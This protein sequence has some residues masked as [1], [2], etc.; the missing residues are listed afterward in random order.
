MEAV[1]SQPGL[2][3]AA[4]QYGTAIGHPPLRQA[5]LDRML[6]A[7]GRSA[8]EL[9][10]SID[11]VVITAGSHQ[12]L[13]LVSD[14]LCDPG[15][16]VICAAPSYYVYLGTLANLGVRAAGVETDRFGMIPEAVADELA[17][18]KTAGELGRVKAIYI[19]SYYDN[20]SGA[21]VPLEAPGGAGG[22]GQTLVARAQDLPDRRRRLP[23]AALCRGGRAQPAG[24]RSG[25]RRR[26]PRRNLFQV[27]F[28]GHSGGLG[29]PAAGAA[30]SGA[31]R[32]GER[33][34]RLAALQPGLDGHRART[35]AFRAA[36]GSASGGLPREDRC[37][38]PRGRRRLGA[39]RRHRL[40]RPQGG[41]YVWLRLPESVDT[42][43]SGPLFARALA[44]GVLYVPGEYCYPPE[45]RP[46]PRNMLRLSFGA[47]TCRE[48]VRGV[49]ALA[50]AIRQVVH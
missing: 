16:I 49:R 9:A 6:R 27:V 48:L 32:K 45:G 5:V 36:T 33:R 22:S 20:P 18:R 39:H 11:S 24:V 12:L 37:L 41:L 3:R 1:W 25:R 28:A 47:V 34:F 8:A 2:A 13:F 40:A 50:G 23:R 46:R 29:R 31:G 42:G 7:D 35:G 4:L 10:A 19:T 21:T 43:L 38:P 14:V 17:R 15:D 44:E 30:G 26:G